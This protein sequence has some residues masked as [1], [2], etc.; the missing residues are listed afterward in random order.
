MDDDNAVKEHNRRKKQQTQRKIIQEHILPTF[1][2]SPP[3][4]YE[5]TKQKYRYQDNLKFFHTILLLRFWMHFIYSD[6]N[7]HVAIPKF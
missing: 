2:N 6:Q 5:K 1:K 3:R 4:L 7:T